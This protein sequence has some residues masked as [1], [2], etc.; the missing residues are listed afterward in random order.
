MSSDSQPVPVSAA[1][2]SPCI[3]ACVAGSAAACLRCAALLLPSGPS[4]HQPRL[5]DPSARSGPSRIC[6]GWQSRETRMRM[7]GGEAEQSSMETLLHSCDIGYRSLD[8][9]GHSVPA[10]LRAL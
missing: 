1:A 8:V 2:C 4:I 6:I 5:A 3:P 10:P 9:V 7:R